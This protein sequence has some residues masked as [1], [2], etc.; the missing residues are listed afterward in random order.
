MDGATFILIIRN[1]VL[2]DT[3]SHTWD[4]GEIYVSQLHCGFLLP[5]QLLILINAGYDWFIRQ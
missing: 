1:M 5:L 3:N 2:P 4:Y